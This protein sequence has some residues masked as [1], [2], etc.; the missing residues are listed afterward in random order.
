MCYSNRSGGETGADIETLRGSHGPDFEGNATIIRAGGMGL[1]CGCFGGGDDTKE[2]VILIKGT[3]CF[4][5]GKE[6]DPA[7]KYS[8]ALA[9]LKAKLQSSS[10]GIHHVTIET[11]L[12]DVEWELGFQEKQTAQNFI[13]KF[14]QQ[15]AIGEADEVR[16]ASF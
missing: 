16:K 14:L 1:G 7:P 6:S 12:G 9:H 13:D 5:F 15:A 4:V 2:K 10:H 11:S 8:I 3:Y